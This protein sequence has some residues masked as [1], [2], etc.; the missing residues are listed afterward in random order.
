MSKLKNIGIW[1]IVYSFIGWIYETALVS[2]IEGHFVNRGFLFIPLIP[3]Y[4]IGAVLIILIFYKRVHNTTKLFFLTSILITV[5]EYGVAW[6]LETLFN[7]RWWDYSYY[8]FH[9][10]GRVSLI[11]VIIFALMALL[12]IKYIHP[13]VEQRLAIISPRV[14]LSFVGLVTTMIVVDLAHTVSYLIA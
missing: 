9:I 10:H 1:F 7:Q 11:G 4:G 5:L 3:I 14:K 12:L 8:M 13:R 2:I 6:L